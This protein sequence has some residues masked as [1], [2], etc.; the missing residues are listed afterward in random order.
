MIDLLFGETEKTVW[1]DLLYEDVHMEMKEIL[2]ANSKKHMQY[3]ENIDAIVGKY[4]WLLEVLEGNVEDDRIVTEEEQ[5]ALYE[6]VRNT[7][8]IYEQYTRMFYA[9]G[10]RNG[11]NCMKC[12]TAIK[13]TNTREE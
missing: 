2:E 6:V 10:W 12:L 9:L 11:L 13:R 8:A 3:R 4:P 7:I 1:L 5:T